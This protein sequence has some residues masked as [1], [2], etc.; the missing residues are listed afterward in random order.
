MCYFVRTIV[1]LIGQRR[2]IWSNGRKITRKEK[3]M[4]QEKIF[5]RRYFFHHEYFPWSRPGLNLGLSDKEPGPS[6]VSYDTT[7][8]YVNLWKNGRTGQFLTTSHCLGRS[9]NYFTRCHAGHTA[10]HYSSL[11]RIRCP[12]YFR[13]FVGRL[14]ASK[15]RDT[16]KCLQRCPQTQR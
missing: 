9:C 6:R 11:Y 4:N 3:P 14:L 5:L 2:L 12:Q 1:H 10:W 8:C 16:E 7:S 13:P 15:D